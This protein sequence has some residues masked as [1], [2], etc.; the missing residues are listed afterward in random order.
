M[1]DSPLKDCKE[2]L[3][4][5]LAEGLQDDE[6]VLEYAADDLRRKGV[7]TAGKKASRSA[8]QGLVASR[9]LVNNNETVSVVVEV[10]SE[11]DFVARNEKFQGLVEL[12]VRAASTGPDGFISAE[13][14]QTLEDPESKQLVGP[15]VTD[16]V[17]SIRENIQVRR[18]HKISSSSSNTSVASYIHSSVCNNNGVNMGKIGCLV[19]LDSTGDDVD[20]EKVQDLGKKLSMHVAAQKPGY[21]SQDSVPDGDLKKEQDILRD[22]AAAEGRSEKVILSIIK[23][24]T[25]KFYAEKVLLDQPFIFEEKQSIAQVLKASAGSVG[26][27]SLTVAQFVRFEV[28]EGMTAEA[29]PTFAEEVAKMADRH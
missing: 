6:A 17:A 19:Q 29:S 16:L 26:A 22:Q 24:R 27:K 13:V 10:N 25:K 12:V 20:I 2:S 15:A 9:V 23:G 21:L 4:A 8:M 11:T 18:A 3:A 28:G 5:A 1:T 7:A 14:L